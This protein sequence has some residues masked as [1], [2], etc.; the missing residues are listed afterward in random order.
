[1]FPAL[2]SALFAL[3]EGAVSD[4]LETEVGFHLLLNPPE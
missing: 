2:D 4:V 3:Q 1:L